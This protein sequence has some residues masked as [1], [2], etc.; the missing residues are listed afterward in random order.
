M[1]PIF[2]L[3]K[4]KKENLCERV[5][6]L[7]FTFPIAVA[8]LVTDYGKAGYVKTRQDKHISRSSRRTFIQEKK[9]KY[10]F[11]FSVKF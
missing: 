6:S 4:G 11:S 3:R 5:R 10:A 1:S 9:L 8:K 2:G 7:Q